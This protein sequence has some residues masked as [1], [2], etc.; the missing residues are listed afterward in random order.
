MAV[1][2]VTGELISVWCYIQSPSN[3]GES[4]YVCALADIKYECNPP[5]ILT[6]AGKVYQ[7]AGAAI[8][9]NNAEA[10]KYIGRTVTVTGEVSERDGIATLT[11]TQLKPA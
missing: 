7:L 1:E 9:V 6:R 5:G 4:G 8:G 10:A 2:T 3:V 11:A